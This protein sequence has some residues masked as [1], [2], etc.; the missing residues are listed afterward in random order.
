MGD[1]LFPSRLFY[2]LLKRLGSVLNPIPRSGAVVP[3]HF[4]TH[5]FIYRLTHIYNKSSSRLTVW[6]I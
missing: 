4:Q 6:G 2:S 3:P 1:G 5:T